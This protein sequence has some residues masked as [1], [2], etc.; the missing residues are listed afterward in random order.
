MGKLILAFLLSCASL[1]GINAQ[2]SF[3]LWDKTNDI[4]VSHA[5]VY[6][7]KNGEVNSTYSGDDGTVYV[8]FQFEDLI[9]SHVNYKRKI[10]SGIQDTIY[11]EPNVQILSEL[12][13]KAVE[14]EW[15]RPLL[16]EFLK[17]KKPMYC[18]QDTLQYNYMSQNLG[19]NS[20]YAFESDGFVTKQELYSIHPVK[21]TITYKDKTA[22]CDF[23]ALKNILYHDFVSDI[24]DKFIKEHK[25]YV[26]DEYKSQGENI[27]RIC[28]KS[29]KYKEDSGYFLIDTLDNVL[30][31][32][33]R[34]TG[35]DYN[36]KDRTNPFVRSTFS[37]LAGHKYKKWEIEYEV[38]Y[39]RQG[40][41]YYV[42]SCRYNNMMLEEFSNKKYTG[43]T[44]NNITSVYSATP[45]QG[46]GIE[47]KDFLIL[48]APFSMKIIQTKKER[49]LEE[50][51]Q[52]VQKSYNVY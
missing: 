10:V 20:L 4:P 28:F 46:G 47:N 39:C 1:V 40:N 19:G 45:L 24:N 5:S 21:N 31:K 34:T 52:Q 43:G 23:S 8:N 29:I 32:A 25:F 13:V 9:I 38:D 51:L 49:K 33:K 30:L 42:S 7:T 48:P 26:D 11:M 44:F 41:T 36:V 2:S 18:I 15:I 6:T 37:L 12:V 50:S 22:G 3:I 14:P 17:D 35:L 27:V 16:E